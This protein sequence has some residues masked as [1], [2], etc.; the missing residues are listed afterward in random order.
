VGVTL[1]PCKTSFD[2]SASAGAVIVP[3]IS[4]VAS[5]SSLLFDGVALLGVLPAK[6]RVPLES[7]Q[8]PPGTVCL[9]RAFV[10]KL[11]LRTS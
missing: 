5:L 8:K 11:T 1:Q 6:S 4:P 10:S 3:E 7:P 9:P 2:H